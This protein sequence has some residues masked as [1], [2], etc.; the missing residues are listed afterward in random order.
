MKQARTIGISHLRSCQKIN[1]R[2]V[3]LCSG[4][5]Q[6]YRAKW[7]FAGDAG[8]KQLSMTAGDVVEAVGAGGAARAPKGW[9]LVRSTEGKEGFV[10]EVSR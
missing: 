8:K 2:L 7:K 10:P 9:L 6:R 4:M 5:A 1:P 3:V